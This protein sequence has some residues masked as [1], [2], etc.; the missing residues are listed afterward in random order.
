[1]KPGSKGSRH[2]KDHVFSHSSRNAAETPKDAI[3]ESRA[4]NAVTY[5]DVF[6][7]HLVRHLVLFEDIVV[8][9]CAGKC[10]SEEEAE[11][12]GTFEDS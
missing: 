6:R 8:D 5:V 9:R 2:R 10:R 7:Q 12:P 1:M 3:V 11:E 4:S